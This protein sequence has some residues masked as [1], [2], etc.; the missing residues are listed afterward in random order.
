M[1]LHFRNTYF[2]N[3]NFN[4]FFC[5]QCWHLFWMTLHRF[6][7]HCDRIFGIMFMLFRDRFFYGYW[8]C[9]FVG[10][11]YPNS[12]ENGP[13]FCGQ[14]PSFFDIFSDLD[15]YFDLGWILINFASFWVHLNS[16]LGPSS[17]HFVWLLVFLFIFQFLNAAADI[18]NQ[19]QTM[20]RNWYEIR[21]KPWT[22]Q[23]T[24][25]K[26]FSPLQNQCNE[27]ETIYA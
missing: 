19:T 27:I 1:I 20:Q 7:L 3:F 16:I 11:L 6:W 18:A 10:G 21:W 26:W 25:Q 24:T 4:D 12:A 9:V 22:P 13:H 8:G 15:F 2:F 17:Y 23:P 14:G 5:Y